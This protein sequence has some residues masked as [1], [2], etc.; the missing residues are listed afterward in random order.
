[1]TDGFNEALVQARIIEPHPNILPFK[2]IYISHEEEHM[3]K[4]KVFSAAF[5]MELCD[6]T[7]LHHINERTLSIKPY[8]KFSDQEVIDMLIQTLRGLSYLTNGNTFKMHNII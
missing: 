2:E 8:L 7:L 3:A 5:V 1:L 4:K 6:Q